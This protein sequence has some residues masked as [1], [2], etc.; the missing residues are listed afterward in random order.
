MVFIFQDFKFREFCKLSWTVKVQ[1]RL[2]I[3]IAEK[4]Y[5]KKLNFVVYIVIL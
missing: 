1:Q 3:Y 4:F 5:I 2:K